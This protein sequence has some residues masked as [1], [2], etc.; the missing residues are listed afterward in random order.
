MRKILK[1]NIYTNDYK[2][3]KENS[4]KLYVIN[5]FNQYVSN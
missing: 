5:N 2:K 1:A 3:D 4:N